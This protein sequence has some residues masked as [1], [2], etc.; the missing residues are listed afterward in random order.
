MSVPVHPIHAG[1]RMSLPALAGTLVPIAFCVV[2]TIAGST[3]WWVLTVL[4]VSEIAVYQSFSA[5]VR[6]RRRDLALLRCFGA[7]RGQVFAG[8]LTEAAWC[9]LAGAL[10]GLGFCMIA[11]GLYKFD[12]AIFALLMGVGGAV[13]GAFVPAFRAS[14]VPPAG[15]RR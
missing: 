1:P 12:S 6:R 4:L 8:V 3:G 7:S 2:L 9:G 14:R 15:P 10:L 13:V 5:L 11:L